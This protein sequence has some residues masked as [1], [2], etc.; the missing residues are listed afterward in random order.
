MTK[1]VCFYGLIE[2]FIEIQSSDIASTVANQFA[3][4]THFRK[5]T[6]AINTEGE[7]DGIGFDFSGQRRYR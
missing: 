3:N 2:H 5:Q 4:S 1:S 6:S 7:D